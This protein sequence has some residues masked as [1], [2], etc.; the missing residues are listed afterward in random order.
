MMNLPPI[1]PAYAERTFNLYRVKAN[2]AIDYLRHPS[3]VI[4]LQLA[5]SHECLTKEIKEVDFDISAK[6]TGDRDRT[7]QTVI[8]KGKKVGFGSSGL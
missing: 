5:A 3:G 8:G 1:Y 6:K 7:K 2:P 4:V